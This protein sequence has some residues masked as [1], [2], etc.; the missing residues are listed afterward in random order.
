MRLSYHLTFVPGTVMALASACWAL[1]HCAWATCQTLQQ[2]CKAQRA[3]VCCGQIREQRRREVGRLGA[4][5]PYYTGTVALMIASPIM[6]SVASFCVYARIVPADQFSPGRI[7]SSLALF[8]LLKPALEGLPFV[9]V[10]VRRACVTPCAEELGISLIPEPCCTHA[11]HPS[12]GL[13][14]VLVEV[15]RA[16]VAPTTEGLG[17]ETYP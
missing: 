11:L 17:S 13:P 8:G 5:I 1:C 12:R 2:A 14:F 6:A 16:C 9:L 7:F 4:M 3:P 10:E 15:R